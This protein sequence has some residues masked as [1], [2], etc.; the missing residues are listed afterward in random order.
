MDAPVLLLMDYQ[1]AIC[2]PDGI[3]GANGTG[4]E[5]IRRGVLERASVVLASFR[6]RNQPVVHTHLSVDPAGHRITSSSSAFALIREHGLMRDGDPAAAIC[7]EVAPFPDEPVIAKCGFGPFAGTNLEGVLHGFHATELVMGGVSTNHV[8]ESAVR[9]ASDIGFQVVVLE[10]LCACD[11]PEAHRY[12]T[13]DI[14]PRY[15][16]VTTSDEYL[17]DRGWL[18]ACG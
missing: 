2:R 14:L 13:E 7:A 18:T 15:A 1:E 9:H 5:V 16:V 8:V 12:A 10:D 6:R 11:S 3:F 17:R 4:A